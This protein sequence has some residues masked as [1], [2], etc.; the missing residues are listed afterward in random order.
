VPSSYREQVHEDRKSI[1]SVNEASGL[2]TLKDLAE[3]ATL[4]AF[5]NGIRDSLEIRRVAPGALR[6]PTLER[7]GTYGTHHAQE[8]P[9]VVV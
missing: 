5:S 3:Q 6:K 8:F 9:S 1:I 7:I 4:V 2:C